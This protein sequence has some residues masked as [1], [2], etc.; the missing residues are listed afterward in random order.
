MY[1]LFCYSTR[2]AER[3]EKIASLFI[4]TIIW[5]FSFF[6]KKILS[7]NFEAFFWNFL[8]WEK[9]NL[10]VWGVTYIYLNHIHPLYACCCC[11]IY[12]YLLYHWD[13]SGYIWGKYVIVE[14]ITQNW[15]F[16]HYHTGW[17]SAY[18]TRL[19]PA[20]SYCAKITK[21]AQ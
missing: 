14:R 10:K 5:V 7:A 1:Y 2:F 11:Y 20:S 16:F 6:P 12:L 4:I 18:Y 21:K 13:S 8:H 17:G 19:C 15:G 3:R 9:P